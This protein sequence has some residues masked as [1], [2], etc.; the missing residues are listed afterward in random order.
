MGRLVLL[1]RAHDQH[2]D[3]G[4]WTMG[5]L[6]HGSLYL[7][8][9]ISKRLE[10]QPIVHFCRVTT[11]SRPPPLFGVSQL[12]LKWPRETKTKGSAKS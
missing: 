12:P 5:S 7:V 2:G 6:Q 8:D 4:V 1:V 9:E 11:K 3:D 10:H